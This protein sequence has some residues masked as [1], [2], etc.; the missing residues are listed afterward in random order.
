MAPRSQAT[1]I[2]LTSHTREGVRDGAR[3]RLQSHAGP[4]Q[5]RRMPCARTTHPGACRGARTRCPTRDPAQGDHLPR[6]AGTPP[7]APTRGGEG[8]SQMLAGSKGGC[9]FSL[10]PGARIRSPTRGVDC[11]RTQ[12]QLHV[13][14]GGRATDGTPCTLCG[15][16]STLSGTSSTLCGT[17]STLPPP[18]ICL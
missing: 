6:A 4:G 1:P 7:R 11:M 12:S 5:G 13:S 15:T 2:L 17:P 8:T 9:F 14:K 16:T 3:T 10:S 18:P